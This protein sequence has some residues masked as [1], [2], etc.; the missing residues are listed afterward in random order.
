MI[1]KRNITLRREI[2]FK[3]REGIKSKSERKAVKISFSYTLFIFS[4]KV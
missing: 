3:Q 4:P 2:A 1:T